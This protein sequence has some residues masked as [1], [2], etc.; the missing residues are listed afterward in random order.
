MERR[1]IQLIAGS[2]YTISLPKQW[3]EKNG[4]KPKS[5]LLVHENGDQTLLLSPRLFLENRLSEI[6]LNVE[7]YG[8]NIDQIIF[9]VY[10]M[11]A[12]SISVFSK[13]EL[14]KPIKSRV[15]KAVDHMSGAEISYEDKQKI[16][17]QVFLD[18]NKVNLIQIF[19]RIFLLLEL[20][21]RSILESIDINE[22]M[23]NEAEIDRLYHLSAKTITIA[24]IDCNVLK[25]SKIL[26]VTL[27]PSYFL[28]AKK[29]ENMGDDIKH[30]CEYLDSNEV[31]FPDKK[32]IIEFIFNNLSRIV[33]HLMKEKKPILEKLDPGKKSA[34]LELIEKN[35]DP[36][37]SNYLARMMRALNDIQDETVTISFYNKLIEEKR[38]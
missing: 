33:K 21:A 38:I 10:Y 28:I 31:E 26:N 27:V 6:S 37:V 19:Y 7:V 25:S 32:R 34:I 2:T 22:I 3:V 29:L 15:R 14:Q 18:K 11:G 13:T 30:L 17:I 8:P 23:L 1:K 36:L 16:T 4:L 35:N 24:M 9:A 12:E 20:S 5:E